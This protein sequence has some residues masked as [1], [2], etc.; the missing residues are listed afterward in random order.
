MFPSGQRGQTVNLLSTTSVVRIHPL[1]PKRNDNFRKRIV[2]SFCSLH[3]YFFVLLF[4]LNCRFRIK[5]KREEIKEMAALLCKALI[6]KVIYGTIYFAVI[7]MESPLFNKS[8]DFAI[9][10]ETTIFERELSFLFVLFTFIFSFFSF[11]LI[12]VSE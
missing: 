5:D 3:F 2:V 10:K 9:E 1:P 4:S 11:L 7:P 6:V 8:L 12:V